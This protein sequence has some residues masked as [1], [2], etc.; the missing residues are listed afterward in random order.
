MSKIATK[1]IQKPQSAIS[2]AIHVSIK[3]ETCGRSAAVYA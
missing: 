3:T 2:T 1:S